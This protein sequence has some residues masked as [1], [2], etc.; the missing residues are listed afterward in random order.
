M[1]RALPLL[2]SAFV[3]AGVAANGAIADTIFE[4]EHARNTARV[5]GP[6]SDHDA[7]LLNR[8]G[9]HSGTPDWR[10]RARQP[11]ASEAPRARPAKPRRAPRD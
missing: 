5:G 11:A 7:E 4:V 6:V 8:W 1:R 2:T 10:Q 9:A 3:L